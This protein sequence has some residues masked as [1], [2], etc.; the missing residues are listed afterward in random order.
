MKK[1]KSIVS[2]ILALF[3]VIGAISSAGAV[4]A[5]ELPASE[6]LD[7]QVYVDAILGT[8][9]GIYLDHNLEEDPLIEHNVSIHLTTLERVLDSGWHNP[10]EKCYNFTGWAEYDTPSDVNS[11][12]RFRCF[13]SYYP[14]L[15]QAYVSQTEWLGANQVSASQKLRHF[16]GD[17]SSVVNL[18]AGTM[19]IITGMKDW[20]QKDN[21]WGRGRL[22]IRKVADELNYLSPEQV[23]RKPIARTITEN[24]IIG[25]WKGEFAGRP[26]QY[27]N[28][29]RCSVSLDVQ[30]EYS[31]ENDQTRGEHIT[32]EG[33][34]TYYWQGAP[35]QKGKFPFYLHYYPQTAQINLNAADGHW[36]KP[37][38]NLQKKGVIFDSF[39]GYMDNSLTKITG[40]N[41]LGQWGA[42]RI[43]YNVIN[44]YKEGTAAQPDVNPAPTPTEP[45]PTVVA[46]D[47][48]GDW[49]SEDMQ[50]MYQL[51]Q[52]DDVVSSDFEIGAL[53]GMAEGNTVDGFYEGAT[54]GSG[55]FRMIMVEDGAAFE[56]YF[57]DYEQD[58]TGETLYYDN[59]YYR[60][61]VLAGSET[62]SRAKN[63]TD[64][65][66]KNDVPEAPYDTSNLPE[67]T[68][69]DLPRDH[70]AYEYVKIMSATGIISGY[71]DN[72]FR[73]NDTF[74]RAAFAKLL[75][76][77]AG[78][79]YY[80]GND[81]VYRDVQPFD[82]YYPYVMIAEQHKAINY[83]NESDGSKT[84]RPNEPS[85]R[86][87]V[88]VALVTL[89]GLDPKD[90]D[91]SLI[92]GYKDYNSISRDM[93]P[94]VALA[95]EYEIMRGDENGYFSP[96][97]PLTRAQACKVFSIVLLELSSY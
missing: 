11:Y 19:D 81:V 74:S 64:G 17:E 18:D 88:A 83:Y 96:H 46:Y 76:L 28:F 92:S 56:I 22:T 30:K 84:Y 48:S 65:R 38:E 8:W 14:S 2:F 47:W 16:T 6:Y 9:E 33:V 89:L 5:G 78:W 1:R 72:T 67:L 39:G 10:G 93:R 79:D 86:E 97:G 61:D 63:D 53:A 37:E 69:S 45:A 66:A 35:E 60:A 34:A 87:D 55:E 12:G 50:Y 49:Y 44:L 90:A 7:D 13:L 95:Y 25:V 52:E 32:Y 75:A 24:D 20:P 80:E 73:P 31:R 29:V 23:D 41:G 21:S 62:D 68:F 57:T 91:L 4:Y 43:Y 26:D 77:S 94:Y 85:E 40:L 42:L 3:L 58:L 54:I 51:D 71:P 15:D 70:W 36:E 82:W 59:T 27:S